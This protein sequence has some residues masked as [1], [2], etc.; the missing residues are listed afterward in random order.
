MANFS[1]SY[2]TEENM[3]ILYFA[4]DNVNEAAYLTDDKGNFLYIN[5]EACLKLGYA[6]N[7]LLKMNVLSIDSNFDKEKW[8]VHWNELKK[9]KSL[10]FEST[11][12]TK[13]GKIIPVEINANFFLFNKKMF[14]LGLVRDITERKIKEQKHQTFLN[15][16]SI[17]DR[18]NKVIQSSNDLEQVINDVLDTV[19]SIFTSDRAF[20][21]YPLDIEAD[22]WSLPKIRYREEFPVRI[23]ENLKLTMLTETKEAFKVILDSKI[24]ISFGPGTEYPTPPRAVNEFKVISM[25]AM[26]VFPK[27]GKPW[28]FGIQQ[29][30]YQRIWSPEEKEI[31][32]QIGMRVSDALSILLSFRNLHQSERKFRQIIETSNEGIMIL[33]VEGRITFANRHISEMLGYSEK[34]II[35]HLKSEFVFEEEIND[36]YLRLEHR[37]LNLSEDYERK[38]LRKDGK[39]LWT[40]ASATPLLSDSG[41]FIGSFA[42]FSD[43]TERKEF[44]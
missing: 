21:L 28:M 33:D 43:I 16:L 3:S 30:S 41:E 27:T 13:E 8:S 12:K 44:E 5:T 17:M 36:H 9:E 22:S 15:Y 4:L 40:L 23:P 10:I 25:L 24:P 37:R 19:I 31:F 32:E 7:E 29:C 2:K 20:L 26:P 18:L 6:R 34:E 11:H 39:I 35:G 42:M 38:F 1:Q 14:N